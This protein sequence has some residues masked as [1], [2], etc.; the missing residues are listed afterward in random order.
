MRRLHDVY[1]HVYSCNIHGQQGYVKQNS[2]TIAK[3]R[4]EQKVTV[5]KKQHDCVN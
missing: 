2:L 4:C 1:M 5:I 3:Y